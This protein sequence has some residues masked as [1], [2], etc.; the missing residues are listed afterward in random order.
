MNCKEFSD[1][2]GSNFG[3]SHD[4]RSKNYKMCRKNMLI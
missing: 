2:F 3:D 4:A 1:K